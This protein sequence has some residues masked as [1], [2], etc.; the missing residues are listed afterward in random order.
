MPISKSKRNRR[1]HK[2]AVKKKQNYVKNSTQALGVWDQIFTMNKEKETISDNV[3]KDLTT[4]DNEIKDI[5]SAENSTD[6]DSLKD[7]SN[8]MATGVISISSSVNSILMA[9]VI[10]DTPEVKNAHLLKKFSPTPKDFDLSL[11]CMAKDV[12]EIS[13]E[14]KSIRAMHDDKSGTS[15]DPNHFIESVSIYERYMAVGE[16]ISTQLMMTAAEVADQMDHAHE[17]MIQHFKEQSE[18]ASMQDVSVISD[19]Q[20]KES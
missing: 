4:I 11:Q 9:P 20:F 6:W 14:I 7:I 1:G 5:V 8:K 16:K 2:L 12:K 10:E 17:A 15:N 13:E 19:V 3:R 18:Q